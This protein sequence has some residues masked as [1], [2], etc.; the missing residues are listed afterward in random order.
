M[1]T[2][3]TDK[4]K[5]LDAFLVSQLPAKRLKHSEAVSKM[6]AELAVI[7]GADVEKARFA[8]MYHD[9]AKAFDADASNELVKE[10]GLPDKYY[11]NKSIAHSK[12]GAALLEREFGVTDR[13]ILDAVANHTTGRAGMSLLEKIVFVADAVD[14]TRDYEDVDYYRQLARTDLDRACLISLVGTI[15][16]V[17]SQGIYLDEDTL[18]AKEYFETIIKEK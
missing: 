8:G 14:E 9:I 12:L 6:A 11:N 5:E 1:N 13:D 16:H 18:A 3:Y 2:I 15:C 7:Y 10:Y 4:Q 17:K